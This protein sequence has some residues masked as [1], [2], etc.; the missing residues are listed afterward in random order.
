LGDRFVILTIC[1]VYRG[2]GIPIA[3]TILPAAKKRAWRSEWLRML[4]V[5]RKAIPPECTVLVLA[6]RGLYAPWLF[7]RI[8]R[9]GLASLLAHQSG[10]QVPSSR[11]GALLLVARTG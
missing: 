9:L 3:W 6:D 4:R 2:C 8:V 11:P 10:L 7:R 5:L 1:V